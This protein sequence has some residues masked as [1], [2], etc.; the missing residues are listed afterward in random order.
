MVDLY[1]MLIN[2]GAWTLEQV[3]YLWHDEVAKK[4][5]AQKPAA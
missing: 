5:E 4:L 2:Q 1:V 3:P